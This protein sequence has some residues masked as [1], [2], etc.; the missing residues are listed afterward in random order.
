MEALPENDRALMRRIM[1]N[2]L[3]T[4]SMFEAMRE[5]DA[6]DGGICPW[7]GERQQDHAHLL[8][9]CSAFHAQR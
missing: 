2:G 7:C 8:W 9:E 1:N 6:S 3:W 4:Q 5:G